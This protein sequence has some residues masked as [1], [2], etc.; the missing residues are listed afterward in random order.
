MVTSSSVRCCFAHSTN[1]S[2]SSFHTASAPPSA[3]CHQN[4]TGL[5]PCTQPV[6]VIALDTVY[7]SSKFPF[8]H[9]TF[10]VSLRQLLAGGHCHTNTHAHTH[11]HTNTR[12]HAHSLTLPLPP[13]FSTL[14]HYR[15][16]SN[17]QMEHIKCVA[18]GDGAVGK[19]CMFVSYTCSAFP[20]EYIPTV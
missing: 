1:A 2:F 18:V 4:S 16:K 13:P 15:F 10:F 20:G 3:S 11:T 9:Y 6:C 7:K 5:L 12:T 14:S 17:V 19:T 8:L